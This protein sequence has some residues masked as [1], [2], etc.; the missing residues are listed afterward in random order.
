MGLHHGP[1]RVIMRRFFVEGPIDPGG[2]CV[3][4]GS[5][6]RHMVKVLRLGPGD[7]CILMDEEG[8]RFACLIESANRQDV[9]LII[10]SRLPSPPPSPVEI[11]LCQAVLKPG[12]M[13][14]VVQKASELGVDQIHPFFSRRTVVHLDGKACS[15]RL[16]HWQEIGKAA[17]KQAGRR[18]PAQVVLPC[19]FNELISRW[20]EASGLKTIFWEAEETQDLKTLLKDSKDREKFIGIIGPEGGFPAEE[21]ET[22]KKAGFVPVSLGNRILRSETAALALTAVVQYE[23]GDLTLQPWLSSRKDP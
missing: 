19:P 4:S 5:E 9:K 17:A 22:A 7:R 14:F 21:I 15:N 16:R 18:I 2:P 3:V 12:P 23:W 1:K 10:E 13:D 20:Q 8:A 6:A 11:I